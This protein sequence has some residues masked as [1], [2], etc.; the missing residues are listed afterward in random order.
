MATEGA[1]GEP[2][3]GGREDS[4]ATAAVIGLAGE[5]GVIQPR[6]GRFPHGFGTK[7][8]PE[9]CLRRSVPPP[10]LSP[11]AGRGSLWDP[12]PPSPV[13]PRARTGRG[14]G[15]ASLRLSLFPQRGRWVLAPIV[16]SAAPARGT[17]C[18]AR[19]GHGGSSAPR[20]ASPAPTALFPLFHTARGLRPGSPGGL[21]CW[22]QPRRRDLSDRGGGECGSLTLCRARK[23]L[24]FRLPLVRRFRRR[25]TVY[26]PAPSP[27]PEPRVCGDLSAPR[28][29]APGV[30]V[31]LRASN[32]LRSR[33]ERPP[34]W[35][36]LS[37]GGWGGWEGDGGMRCRAS[38]W[39]QRCRGQAALPWAGPG[40]LSAAPHAPRRGCQARLLGRSAPL[41]GRGSS[42]V[43]WQ[44]SGSPAALPL[45]LHPRPAVVQPVWG[46]PG[47]T[48]PGYSPGR[49]LQVPS[50]AGA[51]RSRSLMRSS[52]Q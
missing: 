52:G 4:A 48:S 47:R 28:A 46:L 23:A 3:A 36:V 20:L 49:Q 26:S 18:G 38:R 8:C 10:S 37:A 39:L 11:G 15:S 9:T 12:L 27:C 29:R 42:S 24:G 33:A 1:S 35:R 40:L 34:C 43:L 50:Q 13:P 51:A 14:A 44:I 5:G 7:P 2:G 30:R 41:L 22:Q 32:I 25:G 6:R 17:A 16:P 19:E 21:R 31:W 45:P